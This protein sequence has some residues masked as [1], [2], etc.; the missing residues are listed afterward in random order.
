[1]ETPYRFKPLITDCIATFGK[2]RRAV[3]AVDLTMPT[4]KIIRGRLG[5]INKEFRNAPFK[6]EFVLVVDAPRKN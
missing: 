4:E 5:E 3:A 6:A 1:M 2:D